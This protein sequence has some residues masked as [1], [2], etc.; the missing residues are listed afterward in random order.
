MI[1]YQPNHVRGEVINVGVIMHHPSKGIITRFIL[2]AS[3]IKLRSLLTNQSKIENYKVQKDYI[4]FYLDNLEIDHNLLTPDINKES[5]LSKIDEVLPNDYRLSEPTFALTS[6][7]KLLFNELLCNYI[8]SEFLLKNNNSQ[9]TTKSYVKKYFDDRKLINRKI[10]S[11]IKYNPLKDVSSM[12]LTID[13]VYKNGILNLMQTVPSTKEQFTNW[14]TRMTTLTSHLTDEKLGFYFLFDST[15]ELNQDKTVTQ[16]ID[17]FH[18]ND[19]RVN[20]IDVQS[21]DFNMFCNKIEVEG[22]NVEEFET[23]LALIVGA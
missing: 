19:Q 14:F 8:G 17:F 7:P 4:E 23:D 10:K 13:Y 12:Q 2:D 20:G 16:I 18:S 21:K 11:N 6:E 15:D 3:N 22:K 9:I 1:R 5:F